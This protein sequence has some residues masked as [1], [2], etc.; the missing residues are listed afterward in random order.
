MGIGTTS[1]SANLHVV[2]NAYVTSSVDGTPFRITKD[3]TMQEL[4][5][6]ENTTYLP[7]TDP[8]TPYYFNLATLGDIA[9]DIHLI[10]Y[11]GERLDTLGTASVDLTISNREGTIRTAGHVSGFL[12]RNDI[13]IYKNGDNDNADVYVKLNK[14]ARMNLT[15]KTH[16]IDNGETTGSVN[17]DGSFLT[18]PP[19]SPY[20]LDW[21]GSTTAP[22]EYFSNVGMNFN[23]NVG[24]GTTSP[25]AKLDVRQDYTIGTSTTTD[26][27]PQLR[28][29]SDSYV[30]GNVYVGYSGRG[31]SDIINATTYWASTGGNYGTAGYFGIAVNNQSADVN[32][33]HGITEGEV[34]SQT[35]LVIRD[36]GY[37]GIGTTSPAYKLDVSGDARITGSV[38]TELVKGANP[39]LLSTTSDNYFTTFNDENNYSDSTNLFIRSIGDGISTAVFDNVNKRVGIGTPSPSANLHVVGNAYVTSTVDGTPFRIS[40]NNRLYELHI[41]EEHTSFSDPLVTRYY[42]LALLGSTVSDVHFSGFIGEQNDASGMASIDLTISN[43]GG[44]IRTAGHVSGFLGDNDILIY[45]SGTVATVYLKMTYLCLVN[46]T[47]KTLVNSVN[48]DGTYSTSPPTDTLEWAGSSNATTE[49]FTN[50]GMNFNGRLG[51]GTNTP[52]AKLHIRDTDNLDAADNASIDKYQFMIETSSGGVVEEEIGMGFINFGGTPISTHIPGAAITH[53]RTGNYSKGKLHFKT[54]TGDE[55]G[56]LCDTQMTISDNGYVGIGTLSPSYKL[57]VNGRAFFAEPINYQPAIQIGN[58]TIYDDDNL[59]GIRWGGNGLMGMGL[60]SNTYGVFGK[61]GLAIHIPNTE[62][63]SIKTNGWSSLFAINS[64]TAYFK[65]NV[66]IGATS[67]GANL[68]IQGLTRTANAVTGNVP[69][70]SIDNSFD[71]SYGPD[72][73]F[74]W[75]LRRDDGTGGTGWGGD[76]ILS[77]WNATKRLDHILHIKNYDDTTPGAVGIG[78]SSPY[79][80]LHVNGT[81]GI[82]NGVPARYFNY[83]TV[84]SYSTSANFG[85]VSIFASDDIVAGG[86]IGSTSGTMA[87]SDSR[88][89]SNIQDINDTVALD[90]LRLLKPKTY[91]YKDTIKRGTESVIGFIAQ[92]VK[93]VI[94]TAVTIRTQNIPN[95]Y[96]LVNVYQSNVITFA[97]FNTS[98]LNATSNIINIKTVTGGDERVTLT[99]VIDEH[100]IQVVEDLSKFTGS[101]DENGNVITETITTTY[102]QEEYDALESKNGINITYTPEITKDDYEALTDEEKEVY[103]LSYSKTETVNVG[104]Q[105]FVYGQEVDDFNFL[106]KETIFTIATAALQEVDRQ[107]QAD[108]ERIATLESQVVALLARVETLEN[109]NP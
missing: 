42:N 32:D 3:G 66:G 82:L 96:E 74:R 98:N 27:N 53:E 101:L 30:Q 49:Y 107:Q 95:I 23:G 88:I 102:T 21:T 61:Q 105:I 44:T 8:I 14:Y 10:G 47:M 54:K 108:K 24:I 77:D 99:N 18:A 9:S 64:T 36:S 50:V 11:I 90:Q 58:N 12:G 92:E 29:G 60:H 19:T 26:L 55:I 57:H 70:L 35:H 91:Q 7:V 76:L 83:D 28:V 62:E 85:P 22:S 51:I 38:L 81:G 6:M 37:V 106:K 5:I 68:H 17:Y 71:L 84:L 31:N 103:T 48:Y 79:A 67:P 25:S 43:R 65:G 40:K 45:K 89:K 2:G 15:M 86:W 34:V 94:P 109:S 56:S 73:D 78:T 75:N 33:P 93:E 63:F 4:H 69:T 87:A 46:L 104:D 13:L 52:Y 59:Y 20:T 39:K 41:M 97:N 80:K 100:T 72:R 1:P 16:L